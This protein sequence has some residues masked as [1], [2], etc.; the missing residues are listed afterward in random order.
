VS[1]IEIE[2]ELDGR[3]LAEVPIVPGALAYGAT[4][5]E[6]AARAEALALRALAERIERG[7][8]VPKIGGLLVRAVCA[9]RN[10]KRTSVV[11][12]TEAPPSGGGL[13]A[14]VAAAKRGAG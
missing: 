6:A 5:T 14:Q 13:V 8:P 11:P 4:R 9:T 12:G 10:D 3:W 1:T 7:E 2:Q